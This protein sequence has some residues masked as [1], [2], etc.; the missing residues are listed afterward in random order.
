MSDTPSAVAAA[1]APIPVAS[2]EYGPLWYKR[3]VLFLLFLV[4][5]L[6]TVDRAIFSLLLEPIKLELGLSD[7]QA[8]FLAGPAFSIFFAVSG[9]PLGILADRSNRRNI[10]AICLAGWSLMTLYC[11]VVGSFFQMVLGRIGVGIGEAGGT[12]GSVAVIADIFPPERRASAM[13]FFYI[14]GSIGIMIAFGLG[15]WIA[16]RY[17][18]RRTFLAAGVPGLIVVLLLFL[19]VREPRRGQSDGITLIARSSIA[20]T[21]RFIFAQRSVFHLVAGV[22]LMNLV[23]T[24]LMTF[25]VSFLIRSHGLSLTVAGTTMSLSY[26]IGNTIGMIVCGLL[27]DRLAQRDVRWRCRVPGIATAFTGLCLVSMLLASSQWLMMAALFLWT[28]FTA[29]FAAPS[30]ALLQTLVKPDMRATIGSIQVVL[31]Y[32]VGG[33]LGPLMVG[34]FSDAL[35]PSLGQE[36][37]RY[38]LL[39]LCVFYVQATFHF[40]RAE[41][42]LEV[43][44][45]RARV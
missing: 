20:D 23:G 12:P 2:T 28:V 10:I 34:L 3:Y 13:S 32:A 14:G 17:G 37:L 11:G 31:A 24:G 7:S 5:V 45:A 18:W 39:A 21:L 22:V 4:F 35:A 33:G 41:R 8:G 15:A 16:T 25:F 44:L 27:A 40:F 30:Y 38:A 19:T 1:T 6:V 9:I 29:G 36:A 42:T 43:D 26:G